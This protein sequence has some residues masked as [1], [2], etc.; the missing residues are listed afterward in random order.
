VGGEEAIPAMILAASTVAIVAIAAVVTVAL[1]TLVTRSGLA[2]LQAGRRRLS[3]RPLFSCHGSGILAAVRLGVVL[4]L[5][6]F[7]LVAPAAGHERG[8]SWP[9]AKTMRVVD[10]KRVR[11]GASVVRVDV[12]TTLCSGEGRG[13]R[14][15]GV[16]VWRHFRCTFTTFT[17]LGPGRDVEFRVHPLD[18]RRVAI[19][20]ARWVVG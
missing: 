1:L 18:A 9:A 10:G 2:I 13:T 14:R 8:A 4:M 6:S 20:D 15:G 11:V 17:A 16:R 5:L 7:V 12:E 3:L 19:T